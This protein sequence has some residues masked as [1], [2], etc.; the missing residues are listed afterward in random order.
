MNN[1]RRKTLSALYE[2][3]EELKTLLE[4]VAEEE[5]EAFDNIPENLAGSERYESAEEAVENLDSAVSA[6]EE[7]LEYIEY[8]QE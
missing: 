6:L 5:Q 2:K 1:A 3:V 7:A 4:E 8:A